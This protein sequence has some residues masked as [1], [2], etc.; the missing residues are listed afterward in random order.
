MLVLATL[1]MK[2][3][4][5]KPLFIVTAVLF[6]GA[7]IAA[8]ALGHLG[9]ET[10]TRPSLPT[11]RGG[12]VEEFKKV[13]RTIASDNAVYNSVVELTLATTAILVLVTVIPHY[14]K[15][16]LDTGVD[17]VAFVFAPAGLG[18]L[19]GLRLAPWLG[20][21]IS[22]AR[23]VTLGFV[24]FVVTLASLGFVQ[25]LSDLVEETL[26]P[27]ADAY[28]WTGLSLQSTVA[29]ALAIPVGFAFSLVNVAARAVLHERAPADMRGRIFAVQ[30][31]LGS[32]AS[33]IPLF[34]VGGLAEVLPAR[35][36]ITMV[37]AT[38]LLVA[39]YGRLRGAPRAETLPRT[40]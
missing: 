30:M 28:E 20:R 23:V 13:W 18:L 6:A 5:E 9:A 29:M 25:N 40:A 10:S 33:I 12:L 39:V 8:T 31:V 35:V 26:G 7:A 4:D 19:A 3:A 38:V 15:E 27:V 24:L 2:V 22:N 21:R 11:D 14:V 1:F 16:V 36:L 37:A 34:I 32:L 17:N